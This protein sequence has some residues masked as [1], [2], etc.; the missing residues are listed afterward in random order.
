MRGR[1]NWR[2]LGELPLLIAAVG[3]VAHRN[4][5]PVIDTY[6]DPA[7]QGLASRRLDDLAA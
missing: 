7:L 5:A 3:R 2:A 1:R 6:F 4:P